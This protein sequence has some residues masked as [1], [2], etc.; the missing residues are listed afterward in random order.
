MQSGNFLSMVF[1]T[2]PMVALF[3]FGQYAALYFIIAGFLPLIFIADEGFG[4]M[5]AATIGA[6]FILMSLTG[7]LSGSWL[8]RKGIRFSVLI[9]VGAGSS[10]VL[11]LL[12]FNSGLPVEARI[13]AALCLGL[14]S[15]LIPSSLFGLIPALAGST[16]AISVMSGMLAQGSALGQLSGPPLAAAAVAQANNWNEATPYMVVLALGTMFCGWLLTRYS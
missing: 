3:A 14:F 8:N 7:S 15:G 11:S 4:S 16:A 9:M 2:G 1:R 5:A 6:G 12:V 13:L 10:A